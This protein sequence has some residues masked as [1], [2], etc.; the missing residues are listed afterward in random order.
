[1]WEKL[2]R[3]PVSGVFRRKTFWFR[4][5][6]QHRGE[7]FAVCGNNPALALRPA[8]FPLGA[9]VILNRIETFGEHAAGLGKFTR[10]MFAKDLRRKLQRL[11]AAAPA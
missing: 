8:P 2:Y 11:E 4:H 5:L 6:R 7:R 10:T 3:A 1:V 9:R